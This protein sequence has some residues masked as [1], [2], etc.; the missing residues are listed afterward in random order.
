MLKVGL[1][2][3]STTIKLV[4]LNEQNEI[5]F[6]DY[7]RH[8]SN[9]IS[10]LKSLV[11]MVHIK[12][13]KRML[14]VTATGS[15]AMKLAEIMQISYIQE[16]IACTKAVKTFIPET[17]TVIELGGEDAKI[18]YLKDSLEQRMN[19]VCAGGTGA[20]IDQMAILLNTDATGLN[21]LAKEYKNIY[22]I[23]SRC[24]VFAKTDIQA[25]MNEGV[26]KENIAVSILQAVVNQTIGSLAQ[27][28]PISGNVAFLGGPLY[29]LS[30]LRQRFIE[31]LQL[32][33]EQ[34]I[35]PRD[36][37]Y[38]VAIGAALASNQKTIYSN[39]LYQSMSNVYNMKVNNTNKLPALFAD[40]EEIL[41][42][43]HRHQQYFIPEEDIKQYKGKAYLGIDAGSTTTKIILI[44]EDNKILYSFYCSNKGNP[45]D[46]IV[47]MLKKMY[48]IL[49]QEVNIIG[50]VVI[51]YGERLIQK[52][53]QVDL[54]EVETIAHFKAANSF[55]PGVDFVLDIGG[56][57]MKSFFVHDGV[58]DSIM[59]NEACSAGCG[60]FLETFANSIGM[61]IHEFVSLAIQASNPTDLGTRCTVFMNSKVK[62]AQKE[63]VSIGDISAGLAISIIKNALF[64]VIRLKNVTDLGEKI[65]VQGGTFKNDAVLRALEKILGKHVV[66]PNIPGLMGAYGAALIAKE[67]L[68][69]Q[70]CSN[71]LNLENLNKFSFQTRNRRC[72]LCG[73]HC[74]IKEQWF[75]NGAVY[76]TGNRC[77]RGTGIIE[78]RGEEAPSIY[79]FK[80]QRLFQYKSLE[81][82]VAIRGAIG[83]PRVL[84]MYEDYPFW[85]TFFTSLKYRVVL[86]AKSSAQIHQMGLETIPS[87][88]V[89]YPAKLAHGHIVDLVKKGVKKIFYPCIFHSQEEH[90]EKDKLYNCPV[91]TSYPENIN[92]NMEIL[93]KENVKFMHP[94]LPMNNRRRLIKRLQQ[95]LFDE[96]ISYSELVIAVDN[97]YAEKNAYRKAV[98]EKGR[99]ILEYIAMHGG[100]GV[101]LAGRPY[102]IDPEINHGLPE[103]IQSF[104]IPILSEDSVEALWE[105]EESLRVIDQWGYHSRLYKAAIL[106]SEY[107]YPELEI[108]QLNSFGCGLDAITMD[109]VKEILNKY[110]KIYTSIKLDEINNLGAARI[111]LR[112]LFA[113]LQ[114]RKQGFYVEP[115]SLYFEKP[116]FTKDKKNYTVLAPQMS[117]MH[118]QFLQVCLKKAGYHIIIP[119]VKKSSAIEEGLKYVHNDACY[120]AV[121][122]I[123]Q[124][125]SALKSG[126]FDLKKTAI[127]M[128]HTGG[129]CRASNYIAL[130]RKALMDSGMPGIP[131]ISLNGEKSPGFS[132]TLPLLRDLVMAILY[133]DLLMNVTYRLHPYEKVKGSVERVYSKW[134]NICKKSLLI[135]SKKIFTNN[136]YEIVKDFDSLPIHN[137]KAKIKIGIV[138]E[139]LVKYHPWANNQLV[140]LLEKENMEIILPDLLSF[141][142]YSI[143]DKIVEYDLLAGSLRAKIKAKI[144]IKILDFYHKN[145]QKA[146]LNSDRFKPSHT[147]EEL[148]D[149]SKK[150]LSLANMTGEGWLL[151]AEIVALLEEGVNNIICVQPFGCLPNHIVAKGMLKKLRKDYPKAN[152]LALDYDSAISEVNQVNR[153]KL[154]IAIADRNLSLE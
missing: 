48:F 122:V 107:Q 112:S 6:K 36:S 53:L 61:E 28:R 99:E 91:V 66:R 12:F 101:V 2:I 144:F 71:L 110:G 70:K 32:N 92:A 100:K 134:V 24:G 106:V 97:A 45:L 90:G 102:H 41:K 57:D 47:T 115:K 126:E 114:E 121:L 34:V 96:N 43:Q 52:A 123:G 58:I 76:Y 116:I 23:A 13:P 145:I 132:M 154:M 29:F 50:S 113:S 33:N 73:N 30:A 129:G 140:N 78:S 35:T 104:G 20:F 39:D 95:E 152:I 18:T 72:S 85:F 83:I 111:R 139:I 125:I 141:F 79:K 14:V 98:N 119:K 10:T 19:G 147:I 118:F 31:T 135:G 51:G 75:S 128:T 60:S 7:R 94:F 81:K 77:E 63:G 120:P 4:I 16:V 9:I 42:F 84:N 25:L 109:Q 27:G 5:I 65:V 15:A 49:P 69:H 62:Q 130:L 143:Y 64:K 87:E 103:L 37:Q 153:I 148:A 21:D 146:L 56:Q 80:Y 117:P 88:T 150:Y 46:S 59:L 127:I 133:G 3:G 86:S 131:V 124:M 67:K 82:N 151:T 38:F 137:D 105:D 74:L 138:G 44:S 68:Q 11:D 17:D 54:G 22:S 1:D 26:A 149:L 8:F 40:K 55:L 89:C 136:I 142:Q 93:E 108:I